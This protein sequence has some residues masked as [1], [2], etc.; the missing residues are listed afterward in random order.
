MEEDNGNGNDNENENGINND[1]FYRDDIHTGRSLSLLNSSIR[2]SQS[3]SIAGSGVIMS[4]VASKSCASSVGGSHATGTTGVTDA[5]AS[6]PST[7]SRM[8]SV[9]EES[10]DSE[11][12]G[13]TRA[14]DASS[15]STSSRTTSATEES[16]ASSPSSMDT[17]ATP[18]TANHTHTYNHPVPLVRDH[19]GQYAEECESCFM[20][21]FSVSCFG[22]SCTITEDRYPATSIGACSGG[23]NSISTGGGT[24]S[25]KIGMDGRPHPDSRQGEPRLADDGEGNDF[26]DDDAETMLFSL[27]PSLKTAISAITM[28]SG[29]GSFAQKH[30][31]KYAALRS[32]WSSGRQSRL[33]K[34]KLKSIIRKQPTAPI[35]CPSASS[36]NNTMIDSANVSGGGYSNSNSRGDGDGDGEERSPAEQGQET[37]SVSNEDGNRTVVTFAS[38]NQYHVF[39]ARSAYSESTYNSNGNST[40]GSGSDT[41]TMCSSSREER[42]SVA[43]D[44]ST[45]DDSHNESKSSMSRGTSTSSGSTMMIDGVASVISLPSASSASVGT[46]AGSFS[47]SL[48]S[49]QYDMK[50]LAKRDKKAAACIRRNN[51]ISTHHML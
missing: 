46:S 22:F 28:D 12:T 34:N 29:L 48:P 21:A 14:T 3:I 35:A 51:M 31:N 5:S 36:T 33:A 27:S 15:P 4:E 10:R 50:E 20:T 24:T 2:S 17:T 1:N 37:Q 8:T 32:K 39:D 38:Q 13:Y 47:S 30:K 9:T 11:T 44:S 42:S 6:M 26:D 19:E 43:D 49:G 16:A 25:R 41:T 40:R 7:S 23:G 18:V 45:M